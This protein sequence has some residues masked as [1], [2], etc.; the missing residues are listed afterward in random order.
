MSKK[1]NLGN[2]LFA[3][4]SCLDK[5]TCKPLAFE[6]HLLIK[7]SSASTQHSVIKKKMKKV[8]TVSVTLIHHPDVH[9]FREAQA[10][11]TLVALQDLPIPSSSES[12]V[13]SYTASAWSCNRA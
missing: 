1:W 7:M 6:I 3:S 8:K 5:V 11:E 4:G 9:S 13:A 12:S 2:T 10:I